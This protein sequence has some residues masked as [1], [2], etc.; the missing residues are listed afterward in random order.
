MDR[1]F[2]KDKRLKRPIAMPRKKA[3]R[4]ADRQVCIGLR[5]LW[6]CFESGDVGILKALRE[7]GG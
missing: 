4:P 5:R 1:P 7:Q 2:D 3:A 6:C